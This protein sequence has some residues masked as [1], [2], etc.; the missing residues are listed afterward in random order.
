MTNRKLLL[1]V[2]YSFSFHTG[3]KAA[4]SPFHCILFL[5]V[6]CASPPDGFIVVS[7]SV[8]VLH[9]VVLGLLGF[10]FPG[11]VHLNATLW[12]LFCSIL[13]TQ[14]SYLKC[15]CVISSLMFQLPVLLYSWWLKILLGQKMLHIFVCGILL[16]ADLPLLLY[17]S[18]FV[19]RLYCLDLQMEQSW[20]KA[21]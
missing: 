11:G 15:M 4:T 3:H 18:S 21:P 13:S 16:M 7:S 12:L 2:F 5:V 14:P 1:T 10:V 6:C 20:E 17:R 8:T 9:K 19:L